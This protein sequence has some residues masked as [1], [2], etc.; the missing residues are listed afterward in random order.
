MRGLWVLE[1]CAESIHGLTLPQCLRRHVPFPAEEACGHVVVGHIHYILKPKKKPSIGCRNGEY[2]TSNCLWLVY[3]FR[4][5][6]ARWKWTLSEQ[7][8]WAALIGPVQLHHEVHLE[9]WWYVGYCRDLFLHDDAVTL[10]GFGRHTMI[11]FPRAAPGHAQ[12]HFGLFVAGWLV[13]SFVS[14][15]FEVCIQVFSITQCV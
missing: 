15:C 6:T 8:T 14:K 7:Q 13:F 1:L 12:L 11:Y 5:K 3:Q 2:T 4:T 10:K 9:V